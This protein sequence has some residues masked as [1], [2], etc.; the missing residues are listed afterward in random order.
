MT[1]LQRVFLE[2]SFWLS[3]FSFI[4]LAATLLLRQRLPAA[5]AKYA[6]PVVL[7]VI[8]LLFVVQAIVV[9]QRER[10]RDRLDALIAAVAVKDADAISQA[11]GQGYNS[12][13][14]NRED[15]LAFVNAAIGTFDVYDTRIRRCGVTVEGGRAEMKLTAEATVRTHGGPGEPHVG[16]WRIGWAREPDGWK[17]VSLVPEAM[18]NVPVARLRDLPVH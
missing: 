6:L 15:V 10:I 8:V 9:T 4:L 3:V 18:D 13:S 17:I 16:R 2:S 5:R 7:L 1:C 11:I 14:M 12:E